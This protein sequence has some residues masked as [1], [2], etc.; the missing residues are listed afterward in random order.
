MMVSCKKTEDL[1]KDWGLWVKRVFAFAGVE[2]RSRPAIKQ[3]LLQHETA[4]DHFTNQDGKC[5]NLSLLSKE[6]VLKLLSVTS[7]AFRQIQI[8]TSL[9]LL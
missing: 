1:L 8:S 2:S 3:L 6:K 5:T 9:L 7:L 4:K